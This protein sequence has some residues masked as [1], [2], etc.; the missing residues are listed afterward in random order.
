VVELWVS[1][2]LRDRIRHDGR[3]LDQTRQLEG[4]QREPSE[5][6]LEAEP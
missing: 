1:E 6:D 4:A 3:S 5:P 2:Q